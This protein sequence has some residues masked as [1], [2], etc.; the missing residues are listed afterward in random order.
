MSA[1]F[2]EVIEMREFFTHE[3]AIWRSPQEDGT[4]I[5]RSIPD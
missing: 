3:E 4:G 5:R 2:L 1:I